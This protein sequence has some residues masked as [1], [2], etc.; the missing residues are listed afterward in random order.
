[1]SKGSPNKASVVNGGVA[2]KKGLNELLRAGGYD[3]DGPASGLP[4]ALQGATPQGGFFIFC[5]HKHNITHKKRSNHIT[6]V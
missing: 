4:T 1:M 5:S 6:C 3:E 2:N